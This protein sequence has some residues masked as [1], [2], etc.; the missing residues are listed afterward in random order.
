MNN[1]LKI[2]PSTT[3]VECLKILNE[4]FNRALFVTDDLNNFIGS[5]TE[6]DIR[7][8]LIKGTSPDSSIKNIFNLKPIYLTSEEFQNFK[9]GKINFNLSRKINKITQQNFEIPIIENNKILM[10]VQPTFFSKKNNIKNSSKSNILIVGGF[11]FI[12]SVLTNLLLSEGY[13]VT[14]LDCLL[15][16]QKFHTIFQKNKN[17]KLIYGNVTDLNAH[18]ESIKDIDSIVYLAEI[19]G[20]PACYNFPEIA[21]KTN[22]LSITALATLASY[23]KIKKFVYTSSCSVYGKTPDG[24]FLNEDSDVTP[25]SFY[26]RTKLDTEN[27]LL[28]IKNTYFN[29]VILRLGTVFGCSLR[30]RFDLVVNKFVKDAYVKS[31]I[32]VHGGNQFRPNIC[33]KDIARAIEKILSSNND[34]KYNIFNLSN[35]NENLRIID[36]ADKISS[37]LP[38]TSVNISKTDEDG[39]D[40][41]VISKRFEDSFEYSPDTSIESESLSLYNSLKKNIYIDVENPIYSNFEYLNSINNA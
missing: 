29:P 11:G 33:V 26:A 24:E 27:F 36:I 18:L 4:N 21:L 12:G 23:L 28:N 15:Y 40:Y 10:S 1:F 30:Q 19:V 5:L 41:K 37:V 2:N 31:E 13:K 25:L 20:D 8:S 3:I 35:N 38:N 14:V 6:G 7:R 34:L 16:N 22:Y 39:R 32:N 9:L 17:F